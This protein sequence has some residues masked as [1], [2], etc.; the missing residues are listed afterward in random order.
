MTEIP[1]GVKF[2]DLDLPPGI[3]EMEVVEE[4]QAYAEAN[5]DTKH[6]ACFLGAGAYN[7]FIPSVVDHVLRRNE[8]Y[9]A[10]TPYQPEVS[11]GTLQA[12]YRIPKHDLLISPGWMFQMH[13]I[14]MGQQLWLKPRSWH[15]IS[16]GL[17]GERF[18]F[19]R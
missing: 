13:L 5:L 7:H 3:S 12:I 11:Q 18:F 16:F 15:S 9:T 4:L 14:T 2:P 19:H 8:F 17:S 6:I 1:E 10:Y